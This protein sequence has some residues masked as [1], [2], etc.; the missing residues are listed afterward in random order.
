MA[1]RFDGRPTSIPSGLSA[2]TSISECEPDRLTVVDD[3]L[4]NDRYVIKAIRRISD[5][6]VLSGYRAELFTTAYKRTPP[7]TEWY[8]WESLVRRADFAQGWPN[9]MILLQVHDDWS[10][11]GAPHLPPIMVGVYESSVNVLVHSALV[12]NPAL[13]SDITEL[14]AVLNTK[15]VWDEWARF[16][17]RSKFATDGTGELDVWY[18]GAHVCALRNIYNCYPSNALYVQTGAYSGLDQ[19]RSP[20]EKKIVYTTGVRIY[21]DAT[22]HA[23]MGVEQTISLVSSGFL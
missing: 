19:L 7:F 22:T 5:T 15:F 18:D 11:G 9:P 10:S 21:D 23:Q 20:V 16:V 14:S 2:Y 13:P 12:Q 6:A 17:I 8:E 3:P 4:G 1:I